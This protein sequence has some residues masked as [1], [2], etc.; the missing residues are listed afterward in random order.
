MSDEH[1]YK[2][3]GRNADKI[4]ILAAV[5]ICALL[6][7]YIVTSAMGGCDSNETCENNRLALLWFVPLLGIATLFITRK[8]AD[9]LRKDT[10][11]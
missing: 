5:V 8:I 9:L 3:S 6:I 4:G 10:E 7:N 2:Y 11:D 1:K